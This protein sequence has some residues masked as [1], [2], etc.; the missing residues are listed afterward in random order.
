MAENNDTC[1]TNYPKQLKN[2]LVEWSTTIAYKQTSSFI[3]DIEMDY[4]ILTRSFY[5]NILWIIYN[6]LMGKLSKAY[7]S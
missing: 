4:Y 2:W 3:E 6:G 7:F 1:D 5:V